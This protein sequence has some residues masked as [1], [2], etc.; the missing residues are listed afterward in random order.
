MLL[1][2]VTISVI[3]F[4]EL[5]PPNSGTVIAVLD[6]ETNLRELV[7]ETDSWLLARSD[8]PGGYV[9]LSNEPNFPQRLRAA[10]AR[11]VLNADYAPMC[12]SKTPSSQDL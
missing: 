4:S 5:S 10:G 9:F 7:S 1:A 3:L 11:R 2:T 8:I 12:S 6:P